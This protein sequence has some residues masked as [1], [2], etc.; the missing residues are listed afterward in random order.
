MLDPAAAA[1]LRDVAHAAVVDTLTSK[2]FTEVDPASADFVVHLETE[3]FRDPLVEA[4]E[5]R[6]LTISLHNPR[7]DAVI[8]SNQRGRS[9]VTTLD[10]ETLRKTIVEMLASLPSLGG[11]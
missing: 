10:P 2:G 1:R 6:Y 3:F 4:S 5:K 11:H 9:S 8:W 7:N